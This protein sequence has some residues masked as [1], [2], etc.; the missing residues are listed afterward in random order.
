VKR[1]QLALEAAAE[2]RRTVP[3]LRVKLIGD[4]PLRDELNAWVA[5]HG[6]A[7]W[8]DVAGHIKRTEL[9]H[10]YRRAWVVLSASLAEGWGLT[11]TEAAACGTPAVATDIRGH[12]CSVVDGTTG[13]LAVP[14]LLGTELARVLHDHALRERL[15]AAAMARA[16]TLT[17][18]A[19]ATGVLRVLH[20]EALERYGAGAPTAWR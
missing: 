19:S 15:G 5:R 4:G 3:N 6:A 12:R 2:A 20:H 18:E 14:E 16:Q 8:V 10:E 7:S 11:L 9:L 17:W 1:F 13:L